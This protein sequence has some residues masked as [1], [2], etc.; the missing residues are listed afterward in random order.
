MT[1]VQTHNKPKNEHYNSMIE[2]LTKRLRD[3]KVELQ[4]STR[5]IIALT[6]TVTQLQRNNKIHTENSNMKK[7][8]E[9]VCNQKQEKNRHPRNTGPASIPNFRKN[10]TI[11]ITNRIHK[12]NNIAN[13]INQK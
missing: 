2:D 8:P 6:T 7:E 11:L 3:L 1:P 10:D 13:I 9:H 4:E 12:P 5:E